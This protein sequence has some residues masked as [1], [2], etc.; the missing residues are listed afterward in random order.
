MAET[1]NDLNPASHRMF[2]KL[3]CRH[4]SSQIHSLYTPCREDADER[5]VALMKRGHMLS[6]LG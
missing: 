2:L 5:R 1:V 3:V 6:V 4:S